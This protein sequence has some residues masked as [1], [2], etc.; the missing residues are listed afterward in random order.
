MKALWIAPVAV[1][2]FFGFS[3]TGDTR[4]GDERPI[5]CG[6]AL[7][8]FGQAP[9]VITTG[10]AT[11]KVRINHNGTITYKLSYAKLAGTGEVLF[12]EKFTSA[13]SKILGASS[14]CCVPMWLRRQAKGSH[15]SPVTYPVLPYPVP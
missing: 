6:A 11:F 4:A 1:L 8:G 2:G 3:P 12:A 9:P 5:I 13:N 10:M 7:D 15:L 14:F